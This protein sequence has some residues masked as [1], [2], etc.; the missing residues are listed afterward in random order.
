MLRKAEMTNATQDA[1]MSAKDRVIT[2]L[3]DL[4]EKQNDLIFS[5]RKRL[6]QLERTQNKDT[7]ILCAFSI[8]ICIVCI[9]MCLSFGDFS[10]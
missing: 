5:T 1:S 3:I 2:K 6:F 4:S 9:L 8:G 10:W 7:R